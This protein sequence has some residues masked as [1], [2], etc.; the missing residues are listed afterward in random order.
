M[1][2]LG[3]SATCLNTDHRS[4]SGV[5]DVI[6]R[7]LSHSSLT[8]GGMFC[9]ACTMPATDSLCFRCR[10]ELRPAPEVSVGSGLIG[11]AGFVHEGPARRLVHAL[12]Y[13]AVVAAAEPLADAMAEKIPRSVTALVPV[14]RAALRVFRHGVDPAAVL[15]AAVARR[16]GL[17]VVD[18]IR[19][20]LWWRRHAGRSRDER[21]AVRFTPTGSVVPK[22]AAL[23]DDVLT[24]GATARAAA[25][26]LDG[27]PTLVLAATCASR[28]EP[29]ESPM[30]VR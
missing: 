10:L 18:A 14:P 16:T 4:H 13:R 7:I 24:T 28:M 26:A 1:R 15:A 20:R 5:T 21:S 30:E 22:Y 9:L 27:L 29:G 17:P 8:V 23:V 3:Y 2:R 19:P 6:S 25:A 11:V 12:K